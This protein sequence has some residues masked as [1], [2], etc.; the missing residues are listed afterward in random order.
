ELPMHMLFDIGYVGTHGL[1]LPQ[2][3]SL[4]QLPDSALSLGDGLRQLVGNPFAGQIKI[5]PLASPTVTRAQLLRPYPQFQD[6]ISSAASW[7]SSTYNAL[8]I[9][10]EKRYANRFT[11]TASYTYSKMMDYTTGVLH[12]ESYGATIGSGVGDFLS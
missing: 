3:R 5:G 6:V 7:A 10:L 11:V 8:Q 9:K 2:D 12:V 1:K 4:N